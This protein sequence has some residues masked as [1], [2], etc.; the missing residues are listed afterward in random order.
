[1]TIRTMRCGI[2][3]AVLVMGTA[4][5]RLAFLCLAQDDLSMAAVS[6]SCLLVFA[7]GGA[8]LWTSPAARKGGL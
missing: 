7:F 2:V 1:M 5:T 4:C 6:F 8:A 3:A